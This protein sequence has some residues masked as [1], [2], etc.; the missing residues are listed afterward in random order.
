MGRRG[1]PAA[2]A[3]SRRLLYLPAKVA[4]I[5]ALGCVGRAHRLPARNS[6][7]EALWPAREEVLVELQ[8][9][10]QP[11]EPVE[12]RVGGRATRPHQHAARQQVGAELGARQLRGRQ[13]EGGGPG[14]ARASPQADAGGRGQLL[15]GPNQG[16]GAGREIMGVS[17]GAV[18]NR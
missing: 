16:R 3:S 1:E 10:H 14:G 12:E 15:S 5:P 13:K 9:E 7:A 8:L 18:G 17:G 2:R 4:S 6:L 11:V